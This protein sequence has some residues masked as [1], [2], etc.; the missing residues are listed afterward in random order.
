MVTVRSYRSFLRRLEEDQF[1][2]EFYV[3]IPKALLAD[4]RLTEA[5]RRLWMILACF[6]FKSKSL[7]FPARRRLARL[8]GLQ[9]AASVSRLSSNL[10][11]KGY[12]NKFRDAAGRT[13]YDLHYW[14]EVDTSAFTGPADD[15]ALMPSPRNR[16]EI[17]KGA[18]ENSGVPAA[19]P[20]GSRN[21]TIRT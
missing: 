4:Q 12:L 6:A 21:E 2:D 19:E 11:Q 15:G 20:P 10:Q 7:V 9:K 5:E 1:D 14:P 16:I 8:M 3:R 17:P 18:R 13:F